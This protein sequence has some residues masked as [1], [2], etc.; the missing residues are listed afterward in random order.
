VHPPVHSPEPY[1]PR[2][3]FYIPI[4]STVKRTITVLL[5]LRHAQGNGDLILVPT[6]SIYR[7]GEQQDPLVRARVLPPP[8]AVTFARLRRELKRSQPLHD[9]LNEIL[10]TATIVLFLGQRTTADCETH[11]THYYYY[12]S[13]THNLVKYTSHIV[14]SRK[15]ASRLFRNFFFFSKSISA[16][17]SIA[18]FA[19]GM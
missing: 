15:R 7:V 12:Y 14:L 17:L 9:D 6:K 8:T 11:T 19:L 5:F 2:M 10:I 16:T 18:N 4:S 1:P 13:V 3:H